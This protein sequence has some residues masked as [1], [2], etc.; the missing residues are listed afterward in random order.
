[1]LSSKVLNIED[2][3][4]SIMIPNDRSE[5][6]LLVAFLLLSN[7]TQYYLINI[8]GWGVVVESS[9]LHGGLLFRAAP[10]LIFSTEDTYVLLALDRLFF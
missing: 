2:H 10:N 8:D 4:Q 3:C 5:S 6:Y 1:M 9:V 7:K